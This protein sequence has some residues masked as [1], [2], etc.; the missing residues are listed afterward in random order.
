MKERRD[1]LKMSETDKAPKDG[2]GGGI[3]RKV[4]KDRMGI[5]WWN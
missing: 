3:K 2:R 1:R 4:L 5:E